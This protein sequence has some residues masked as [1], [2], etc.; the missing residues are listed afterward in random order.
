VNSRNSWAYLMQVT[1]TGGFVPKL[2]EVDSEDGRYL[3]AAI[4]LMAAPATAP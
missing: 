1:V 3:G 4:T 2:V